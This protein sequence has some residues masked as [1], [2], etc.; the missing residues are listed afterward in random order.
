MLLKLEH[1]HKHEL[2]HTPKLSTENASGEGREK[3][4]THPRDLTDFER[5]RDDID[6]DAPCHQQSQPCG[7][8]R[9]NECLGLPGRPSLRIR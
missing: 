5:K 4:S 1:E 8:G 9:L 7:D 6:D 3:T 2:E